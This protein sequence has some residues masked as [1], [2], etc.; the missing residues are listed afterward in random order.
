LNKTLHLD[1]TEAIIDKNKPKQRTVKTR[2]NIKSLL[3][4]NMFD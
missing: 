3:D 2:G 4:E 1:E